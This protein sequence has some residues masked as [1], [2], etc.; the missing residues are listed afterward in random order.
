MPIEAMLTDVHVSSAVAGL[1]DLGR[2]GVGVLALGD[3]WRS[4][5]LWSRYARRRATAPPSDSDPAGFVRAVGRAADVHGPLV[6]YP[7]CE[8]SLQALLRTPLPSPRITLPYPAA[9]RVEPL[10]DKRRLP[11][12]AAAAGLRAPAT[13]A[14]TSLAGLVE[15]E[16]PP[17]YVVKPLRPGGPPF[18]SA[19][20]VEHAD[21]LAALARLAGPQAPALAQEY[22]AGPQV[23]VALVLDRD[24]RVVERFQHRVVRMSP[25]EGGA[26]TLAVSVPPDEA[27]VA[28][29]AAMLASAGYWGLAQLDVVLDPSRPAC[30]TDVNPRY[31][32]SMPLASACGVNLPAAWHRLATDRPARAPAPPP[33]YATGV[34]YRW[35]AVD[36]HV[37]PGRLRPQRGRHVGPLWDSR[38]PVAASMLSGQAVH[39]RLTALARRIRREHRPIPRSPTDGG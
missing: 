11:G 6:V 38:D 17:P 7:G 27:L 22:V 5:G 1:R 34:A 39:R 25:P 9:E 35:W 31:Y 36:V 19:V 24:G 29:A 33:A 32:L 14:E 30:I 4:A 12:L 15:A 23:S 8:A 2:A 26:T 16:L 28:R 10:R 20:V 13:L 3:G 37:R 21:D 18:N